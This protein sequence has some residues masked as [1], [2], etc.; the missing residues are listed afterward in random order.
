MKDFR[1]IINP[2]AEEDL[3]EAKKWYDLQLDSLGDDFLQEI[4]K[5]IFHIQENPFQFQ[6]VRK[7]T[8]RAVVKR[9]PYLVYFVVNN[10]VINVFAV[11]HSS[12][13]PKVWKKRDTG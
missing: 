12:R 1:L 9:F 10:Q 5:T 8:R 2:F 13:S 7:Q 11:F 3:K 4:R 6:K